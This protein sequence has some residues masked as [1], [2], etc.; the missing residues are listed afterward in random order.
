M[1]DSFFE[2]VGLHFAKNTYD[3][4]ELNEVSSPR[5]TNILLWLGEPIDDNLRVEIEASKLFPSEENNCNYSVV[6]ASN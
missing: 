6:C 2:V 4:V 5:G 3:W 1:N